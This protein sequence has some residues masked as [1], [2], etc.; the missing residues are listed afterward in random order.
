MKGLLLMST[1]ASSGGEVRKENWLPKET[2]MGNT[3]DR[4][5]CLPLMIWE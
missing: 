3:L 1:A 5:N 4:A 2:L